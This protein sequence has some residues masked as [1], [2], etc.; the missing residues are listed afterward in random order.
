MATNNK[1]A[2]FLVDYPN[3]KR[4]KIYAKAEIV[5]LKDNPELH[6]LLDLEDYKFC[7]ER[8]MVFHIEAYDWNCPQHYNDC[9]RGRSYSWN[10]Y[11]NELTLFKVN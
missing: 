5:A 3:K 2:L 11:A 7:P 10:F 8:L 9:I 6:H 4:L 1:I